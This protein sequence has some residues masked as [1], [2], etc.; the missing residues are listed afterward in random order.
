MKIET[1]FNV[2]DEVFVLVG[3]KLEK[4]KIHS[5]KVEV[6]KDGT[7]KTNYWLKV[8]DGDG[9]FDYHFEIINELKVFTS[10]ED[11]LNQLENVD[12]PFATI[13]LKPEI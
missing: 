10:R 6:E 5:L 12:D 11:F 4:R 8:D 3:I 1:K 13:E 9:L 7:I 2:G